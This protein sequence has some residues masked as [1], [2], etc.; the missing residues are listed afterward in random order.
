MK[1][2]KYWLIGGL[3]GV[4]MGFVLA[5][6]TYSVFGMNAYYSL[7]SITS[8]SSILVLPL[9]IIKWF[10]FGAILGWLYGRIKASNV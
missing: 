2:R 9:M 5:V 3:L 6:I 7:F 4:L 1:Q 10:V 8:D